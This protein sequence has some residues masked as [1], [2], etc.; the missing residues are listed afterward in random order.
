MKPKKQLSLLLCISMLAGLTGIC[1][2]AEETT[3]DE[4]EIRIEA[5]SIDITE[6]IGPQSG[7]NEN[8]PAVRSEEATEETTEEN[9]EESLPDACFT[10]P[11]NA[12]LYVGQ[13]G[14]THFVDFVEQE[15][16]KVIEDETEARYYF[17]LD[18][19]K[20]YNF[21]VYGDEYVTYGGVFT[22]TPD[23]TM[24][25]TEEKLLPDGKTKE[26]VDRRLSSNNGY[27]V[28]DIFLNI[29]PKGY[30][31]L[32]EN[33]TFQIVSL[34]NWEAV[35]DVMNN[36]FIE[37]DYHFEVIDEDGSPSEVVSVD[38]NGL[39]TANE[40]GTALVLVRYDAMTLNF[41][42]KDDFYGAIFPENT[43]VFVVSVGAADGTLCDGMTINAGKNDA[44]LKYSGDAIDSELDCIYY[45]GESGAYTF[46]PEGDDVALSVANP[47][48]TEKAEYHGFREITQNE[49][50]SYTIPLV[51]GRN[52]VKVENAE[53]CDYRIITAKEVTYTVN[54]GKPVYPG[55]TLS[56]V[57]NTLYGPVG[58]LA[59]VYNS[60]ST[61]MYT[62]VSGYD[63]KIVGATSA[64]YNFASSAA[65]QTVSSVLK[66]RNVWGSISYTKDKALT[67]PSDYADDTFTLSGGCIYASGWGD[68]YGA[69]RLITYESGKDPNLKA[70]ARRGYF[71]RLPDIEIPLATGTTEVVGL[72]AQYENVKTEYFV[73]DTFDPTGL[74]VTAEFADGKKLDVTNYT[75]EPSVL[76]A[77]TS[78]VTV[79]YKNASTEIPVTVTMPAATEMRVATQPHKTEYHAGDAFNPS[80]LTLE[81]RFENGTS[82]ETVE[83]TYSPN[84]ELT[85]EDTEVILTYTG[86]TASEEPLTAT[87][88]ITVTPK[89]ATPGTP[90]IF[91]NITVHFTLLG[92][93]LHGE[94]QGEDDTHTLEGKNLETW[95]PRTK[96][97]LD[98]DSTVLSAVEKALGIAGI[99][100]VNEGNYISE[101]KGLG[102][103]DNGAL[104]GW[105]YTLNGVYPLLGVEEQT[106]RDGDEIV[107]HYTDDYT[108]EKTVFSKPAV[109][110]S[111]SGKPA[112]GRKDNTDNKTDEK[113]ET[114]PEKTVDTDVTVY[115]DLN[116]TDWYY[117]SIR[118][119][120]EKN[121]MD[122]S[123]NA[124][125]PQDMTTRSVFV[126]ALWRLAE[127]PE[128]EGTVLFDD[129]FT[130]EEAKAVRWAYKVGIVKGLTET[131]FGG[132]R[133]VTREQAA[134][135]LYRYASLQAGFAD[136]TDENTDYFADSDRISPYAKKAVS[137][138]AQ[139][140]WLSGRENRMA[141]PESV[142]LR[143]EAATILMRVG[144]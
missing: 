52:I 131:H 112:S 12:H 72:T 32:S 11:K 6:N 109:T 135:L 21:R 33:E 45:V 4:S 117:D 120:A 31:T 87:V 29:N 49:D 19:K 130:E 23:Y 59:G 47:V 1:P 65:A 58:K 108:A 143:C 92:D 35:K 28:G 132:D 27:N 64:Q 53:E 110:P 82:G 107:F 100:F 37:P 41:N 78:A 39:L 139:K 68:P 79:S 40:S 57:F 97:T 111:P 16:K 2:V 144:R 67:V 103:K 126:T 36:Y 94:P 141:C 17:E 93:D 63:G 62:D 13:K 42:N 75:L 51:T 123:E 10:V 50:G 61:A 129:E 88:P 128:V 71:G 25:V 138:A 98:K 3:P 116:E 80:G 18:D 122:G 14:K 89:P 105:M 140:G 115:T 118:Y 114:V 26:T 106:V 83:Y 121:L 56:I 69:H 34:R 66:E 22:K 81:V 54:N 91:Q 102:E 48:I 9:E 76:A 134:A 7:E 101:I 96:L 15:P 77:D 55:D 125:R 30:L 104:S 85:T 74:V 99:P 43:G 142:L 60:S 44:E 137:Y 127:C 86:K 136:T 84:R 70:L 46:T 24:T 124:F 38:E 133:I 90:T 95:I 73:G 119:V 113:T 8:E 20:E 5:E